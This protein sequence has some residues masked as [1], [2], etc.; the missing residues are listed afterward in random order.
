VRRSASRREFERNSR[1]TGFA[2]PKSSQVDSVED[3][4]GLPFLIAV[5]VATAAIAYA[6]AFVALNF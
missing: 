6:L 3:V 1:G 4:L 5:I 2:I